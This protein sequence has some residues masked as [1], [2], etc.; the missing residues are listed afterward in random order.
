[1]RL[2]ARVRLDARLSY[3]YVRQRE[4]ACDC[5]CVSALA[6]F[7]HGVACTRTRGSLGRFRR[8]PTLRS[9]SLNPFCDSIPHS[10]ESTD[11]L[12]AN[13]C[14]PSSAPV[15]AVAHVPNTHAHTC[16]N[17]T[18]RGCAACV[19]CDP[20]CRRQPSMGWF[21]LRDRRFW[22][23]NVDPA[24]LDRWL[25]TVRCR[26]VLGEATQY[27]APARGPCASTSTLCQYPVPVP[28]ASTRHSTL[29]STLCQYPVPV[30][31]AVPGTVP[32]ASTLHST[33]HSTRHSTLCQYP[34]Q[35]AQ[36]HCTPRNTPWSTP[37]Q[38]A[39]C[40]SRVHCGLVSL[41]SRATAVRSQGDVILESGTGTTSCLIR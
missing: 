4:C 6:C 23:P 29:H 15:A 41:K 25:D 36:R 22:R 37:V 21:A 1:M 26:T 27:R 10:S 28:C 33:R 11:R 13:R 32:C 34:A 5:A 40:S 24:E 35:Y 7:V 39:A 38:S 17:R 31:C 12:V 14:R 20:L 9:S 2:C 16:T 18:A 30:P 3:D 19:G 8:C